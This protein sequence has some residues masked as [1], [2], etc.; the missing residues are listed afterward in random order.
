MEWTKL[1]K[2][3]SRNELFIQFF[4]LIINAEFIVSD[5][6]VLDNKFILFILLFLLFK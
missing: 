3:L 6:L 2:T 4:Y 1:Q 5:G